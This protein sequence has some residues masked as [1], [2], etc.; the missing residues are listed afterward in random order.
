[1]VSFIT[2]APRPHE[3][4]E[5]DEGIGVRV[6]DRLNCLQRSF[7]WL[8]VRLLCSAWQ[9]IKCVLAARG[10]TA[11]SGVICSQ[12]TPVGKLRRLEA[13]R[14]SRQSVPKHPVPSQYQPLHHSASF[15]P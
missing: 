3:Y 8:L 7:K 10:T 14:V 6:E 11:A 12:Y 5:G 1:M 15:R 13:G 4:K 9:A 2:P